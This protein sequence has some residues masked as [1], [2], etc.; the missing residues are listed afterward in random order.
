MFA[1]FLLHKG[2][3]LH[4]RYHCKSPR[5]ARNASHKASAAL[6]EVVEFQIS[7]VRGACIED[8]DKILKS[9]QL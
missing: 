5:L 6:T 1:L 8:C 2:A 9:V 7:P 3:H 4:K